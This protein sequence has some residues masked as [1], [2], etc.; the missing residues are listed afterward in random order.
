MMTTTAVMTVLTAVSSITYVVGY[1]IMIDGL[2]RHDTTSE[3]VGVGVVAVLFTLSWAL[4]VTT[5]TQSSG[6]T[7][8]MLMF[9]TARMATLVNRVP[10]ISHLER[11]EYLEELDQLDQE[12]QMLAG[13]PQQA[14]TLLQII[15]MTLGIVVLLGTV[16]LPLALLP[17]AG[18]P[19]FLG[20]KRSVAIRERSDKALAEERRLAAAIF[21]LTSTAGPAKEL[22]VFGLGD[23]LLDRH[24]QLSATIRR[25]T[26]RAA[27]RGALWSALGWIVYA[28]CFA[29]A[30]ALIT[31]RAARH[32]ATAGDVVLAVSLLRRAQLSVSQVSDAIGKLLTSARAAGH[33]M[34][35]EDHAEQEQAK[36]KGQRAPVRLDKGI[37]LRGLSFTYPGTER[38]ILRDL[39][40]FLPAGASV[41]LVG[42]NGAGKTTLVKLLTGMYQ[43]AG[44]AVLVDG[45]PLSELDLESWRGRTSAVFQDFAR[46]ELLAAQAVGVGSLPQVED[47]EAVGAAVERAGATGLLAELPDGLETPLGRSF[48][49]GRD[50][51][52]GQWQKLA[53]AR[54]MMR[55]EPLLLILD[56]PTA[57]LDAPTESALFD[58]YVHASRAAARRAGAITL[59]ISHRFSTVRVAELILVLEDGQIVEQGDHAS[60]MAGAGLYAEL[61]E[62]QARGYR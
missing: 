34:W 47:R 4:R 3:V 36:I 27:T 5:G 16:Y 31:V 6:L 40:A 22:R 24:A 57:S 28:L 56:E 20:D 53:L 29:G 60:L 45:V 46:Y 21:T 61:Y 18:V 50:L 39:D 48:R 58:R 33:L 14:L 11:P 7:D 52:A 26:I 15:V 2:A 41:A 37:T 23:E 8:R 17:L 49:G 32:E 35:L 9:L 13:G 44:G 59:L 55:R 25:A 19:P 42:E 62:L 1:R 12:R 43:P 51:S 54:G 10:G 38:E 30:I